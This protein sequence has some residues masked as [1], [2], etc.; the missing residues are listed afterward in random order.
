MT[1][2]AELP[3]KYRGMFYPPIVHELDLTA[4]AAFDFTAYNEQRTKQL[5][6]MNQA[7]FLGLFTGEFPEEEILRNLKYAYIVEDGSRY[8]TY[9]DNK[10]EKAY[11]LHDNSYYDGLL[12]PLQEITGFT[13]ERWCRGMD[14]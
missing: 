5:E 9:V 1:P 7:F 2:N 4:E 13:F 12:W 10:T 3:E 11:R 14:L 6:K 8:I